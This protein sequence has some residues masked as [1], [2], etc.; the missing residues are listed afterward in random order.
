MVQRVDQS[1]G[2]AIQTQRDVIAEKAV[3]RQYA[4]KPDRWK[5]Y[6]N[7][8]REKSVRDVGY[9]LSYLAEAIAGADPRLFVE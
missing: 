6:G 1:A 9:H 3:A 7:V 2:E 4:L 8:G 5:R